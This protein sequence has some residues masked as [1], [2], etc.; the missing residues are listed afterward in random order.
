[1]FQH[2]GPARSERN[3]R[4]VAAYLAWT[5]GYVNSASFVLLGIFTSHVTGNVG[6]LAADI[7]RHDPVGILGA[8]ALIGAFFAGAVLASV[9]I[10]SAGFRSRPN[11]YAAALALEAALML[12][13]ILLPDAM[14][15]P[16][17]GV[18]YGEAALVCAAMGLQNSLVTR[19]SGA[20]V[21][22][23]HLTGVVTDL[24][25]EAARWLRWAW[26]LLARG[27]DTPRALGNVER[28]VVAKVTL[29]VIVATAFGLGALSGAWAALWIRQEA[30]IV[31]FGGLAV[32]AAYAFATGRTRAARG[33]RTH[34]P[35]TP[36]SNAP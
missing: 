13:V 36:G 22:T 20:V 3:N 9:I 8:L 34:E 10:E 31:P 23:T 30:F 32:A 19:L 2:E 25:I 17:R 27:A 6:H 33:R 35:A 14:D 21:R 24:G 26:S 28:P 29:L 1:M 15:P 4:L 5:G 11:A 18:L 7:W 16:S 12:V